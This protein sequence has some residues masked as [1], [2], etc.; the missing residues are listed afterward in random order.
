MSMDK[1]MR[2]EA[3]LIILRTLANQVDGRFNSELVRR[4]LE[5][6]GITRTRAWVHDEFRYLADMGAVEV[7][8]AGSVQ[9]ASLTGKGRDHVERRLIIEGVK[10]PS[11]GEG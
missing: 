4:T 9:V 3:R 5:T 2:E 1:M 10:R 6:F 11:P 8:D 7:S